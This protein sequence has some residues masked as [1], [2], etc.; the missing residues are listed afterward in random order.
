MRNSNESGQSIRTVTAALLAIAA[1]A[2]AADTAGQTVTVPDDLVIKLERTACTASVP[3]TRS[4]STRVETSTT[5]TQFVRVVGR[6]NDRIP[7]SR[8]AALLETAERI[9]SFSLQDRYRGPVR[10]FPQRSSPLRGTVDPN[11]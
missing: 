9:G 4:P 3:C 1:L 5:E 8:V 10:T 6:Q 7:L 11:E 2:H